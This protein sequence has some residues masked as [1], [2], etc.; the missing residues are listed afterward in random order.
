MSAQKKR[1]LNIGALPVTLKDAL[2]DLHSDKKF[3]ESIFTNDFLDAYI[4]LKR[5]EYAAF[6]QTPTPWEVSM[7]ADA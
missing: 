5:K 2:D 1:E 4:D 7:Y 6:A 3:L